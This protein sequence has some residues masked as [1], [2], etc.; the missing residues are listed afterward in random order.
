MTGSSKQ[1]VSKFRWQFYVQLFLMF[2]VVLAFAILVLWPFN[3]YYAVF[4]GLILVMAPIFL[5]K[6][7]KTIKI[8]DKEILFH[9]FLTGRRKVVKLSEIK[10]SRIF[11]TRIQHKA[12]Q[13][14]PVENFE[15]KTTD[16][17]VYR[18]SRTEYSNYNQLKMTIYK[19]LKIIKQRA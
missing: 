7:I 2:I 12:G 14:D 9:F 4:G 13:T 15:F 3:S 16:G 18:F 8:E 17:S 10:G 1:I 19:R 11:Y 5:F 6:N